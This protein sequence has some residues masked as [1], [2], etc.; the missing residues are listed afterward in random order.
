MDEHEL[1]KVA[2]VA[3]LL[4]CSAGSVYHRVSRGHIPYRKLGQELIFFRSEL[5]AALR[6]LPGLTLKTLRRVRGT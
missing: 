5:E 2:D 4:K 3:K 1:M 6:D